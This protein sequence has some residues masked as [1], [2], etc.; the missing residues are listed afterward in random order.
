VSPDGR[1]ILYTS[2]GA[3]LNSVTSVPRDGSGEMHQ[4]F[5]LTGDTW[6][7]DAAAD[8]SIYADQV[9]HDN[10]LIRFPPEGGAPERLGQAQD[11]AARLALVLPDGRPLVYTVSG[12]NRRFE[13][14]QPDG[15]LSPLIESAEPC[16]MPA[17]LAGEGH[18]AVLTDRKPIQIALVSVADGRIEQRVPVEANSISSLASSPDGKTL[19]YTSA[20][21]VWSMPATGGAPRKLTPGDSVSADASG[22]VLFVSLQD[23]DALRLVQLPVAGGEPQPIELPADARLPGTRL[24]ASMAGPGGLIVVETASPDAWAWR[25]GLIE[26]RTGRLSRIPFNFDGEPIAPVWTRDGKLVAMESV[27]GFHIWRFHPAR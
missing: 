10:A 26:P 25:V 11:Q 9:S 6:Y 8:G 21:F 14:V 2:Y 4:L 19:Y 15:A 13:I 3:D 1:S 24:P 5:T 17:A 23:K 16:G 22:R 12:F 18:V 20:G 27:F 7:L